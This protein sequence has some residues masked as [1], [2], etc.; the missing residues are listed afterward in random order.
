MVQ[1]MNEI[2][3]DIEGSSPQSISQQ[4]IDEAEI[5]V[6]MERMDKESC[7]TLF[8]KDVMDWQI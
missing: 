5:T 2:G 6:N 1:A 4:M 8:L 7:L 3:I